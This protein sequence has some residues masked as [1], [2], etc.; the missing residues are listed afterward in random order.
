MLEDK[1]IYDHDN[2]PYLDVVSI[3]QILDSSLLKYMLSNIMVMLMLM[4]QIL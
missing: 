3:A 4:W 2:A 1:Q